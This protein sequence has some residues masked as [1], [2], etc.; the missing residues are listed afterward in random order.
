MV[1]FIEFGNIGEIV[2]GYGK[3][4][5]DAYQGWDAKDLLNYT[6]VPGV[7]HPIYEGSIPSYK[8]KRVYARESYVRIHYEPVNGDILFIECNKHLRESTRND[9][10]KIATK[11]EAELK[12]DVRYISIMES[13]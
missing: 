12:I 11:I 5:Y 1:E 13:K 7:G 4:K 3:D 2:R 9:L 10:M 8:R 6:I